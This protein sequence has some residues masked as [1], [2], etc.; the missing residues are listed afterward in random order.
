VTT[1]GRTTSTPERL[2]PR[3]REVLALL[4]RGDTNEEIA[5]S[6]GISLDGAKW[7]VS[8]IIGRLGVS[9]RYEAARWRAEGERRPWWSLAWVRQLRWGTPTGVG[10]A[11]LA[12]A[13]A[14]VV[15]LI[16]VAA[17]G[18]G[19]WRTSVDR[20]QTAAVRWHSEA[21]QIIAEGNLYSFA[22]TESG[23]VLTVWG[24]C[25]FRET[26]C[27]YAWRLGTGS[28]TQA[29]G[30]V[31]RGDVRVDASAASAAGGGFVLTG[32]GRP[33]PGPDPMT[34]I[35]EDGTASPIS[36]DC[37]DASWPTRTEPGRRVWVSE[38]SFLDTVTGAVCHSG[39]PDGRPLL[40]ETFTANG[41]LWA[42]VDN[43]TDPVALTIARYDGVQWHYRDLAAKGGSWTSLLAAAGSNVVVLQAGPE[44]S[45]QQLVGLSVTTDDGATWSEVV[46]PDVLERDLPFA[47]YGS[48]ESDAWF[49]GY[50]SMAFAGTSALYVADLRGVLWRSTDF[51]TFSRVSVPGGV[52]DLKSAG[53][54]VIA[55]IDNEAT[56]R[57]PP[58]CQL[59]ELVRISADGSVEP[60]TAR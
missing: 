22:A 38:L 15:V 23:T 46:D 20:D 36:T 11:K 54:A 41:A 14:I 47:A 57:F 19:V 4:R 51:A 44:P 39:R 42:L 29:T 52:S 56:C 9:D 2:T 25:S 17:M 12:S 16:A 5:R 6:L 35:A 34:I 43:E 13:G 32:P 28:R 24:T 8:E 26:D 3:Q 53:D 27:G 7:H 48:P 59:N 45:H 33:G 49:S 18:W 58:G 37:A 31:G 10:A 30:M 60:I 55:R 1:I 50:T 40:Q 21:E